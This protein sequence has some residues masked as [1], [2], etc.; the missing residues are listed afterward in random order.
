MSVKAATK[1]QF[2]PQTL[3]ISTDIYAD[4]DVF[5]APFAVSIESTEGNRGAYLNRV[6]VMDRDSIGAALDLL[7]FSSTVAAPAANAVLEL[8]DAEYDTWLGTVSVVAADYTTYGSSNPFK[9]A[10][11]AGL[12]R[13]FPA[14]FI[15]LPVIRS[16]SDFTTTGAVK[17]NLVFSSNQ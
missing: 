6:L 11:V 15:C 4:K 10:Q 14:D 13:P 17:L 1:I 12:S 5:A 2:V 8:T 3:T 7:F 9:L 16:A